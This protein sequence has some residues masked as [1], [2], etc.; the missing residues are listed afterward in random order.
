MLYYNIPCDAIHF[1]NNTT[2]QLF[3]NTFC[4][5]KLLQKH[6]RYRIVINKFNFW[7]SYFFLLHLQINMFSMNYIFVRIKNRG[8][9]GRKVV[10]GRGLGS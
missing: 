4:L 5:Q 8:D 9:H 1:Y 7:K 6:G 3:Y 10:K 2:I